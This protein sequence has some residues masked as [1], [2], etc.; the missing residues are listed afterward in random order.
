MTTVNIPDIIELTWDG[1]F[2]DTKAPL[3]D[4]NPA[5][6]CSPIN[7]FCGGCDTCQFLQ[8]SHAGYRSAELGLLTIQFNSWEIDS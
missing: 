4:L 6:S 1:L 3:L 5:N 2:V 7:G 8:A